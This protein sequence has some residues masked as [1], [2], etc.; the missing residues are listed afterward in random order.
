M[1]EIS[2][3]RRSARSTRR[4]RA[5]REHLEPDGAL[6]GDDQ[7]IVVGMDER[8]PMLATMLGASAA[9]SS[10]VAPPSITVAPCRRVFSILTVGVP[11]GMKMV[12]GMQGE[13]VI[14]D[15]LRVIAC[16]GRDHATPPFIGGQRRQPVE[17]AALL[18]GGGELQIFEL[19]PYAC[20]GDIGKRVA[21]LAVRLLHKAGNRARRLLDVF[22]NNWQLREGSFR[23]L[24]RRYL[25]S[26]T[27]NLTL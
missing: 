23:R 5:L 11:I 6:T 16:G 20:A 10:S 9:A 22:E 1:P 18:E 4:D 14:G 7:R 2:P 8:Q 3:P 15:T 25:L 24:G 19:E 17:R 27:W 21:A 26:G 13:R 12:A